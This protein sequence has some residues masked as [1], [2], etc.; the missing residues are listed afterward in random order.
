[1]TATLP[2]DALMTEQNLRIA[3]TLA[4]ER[5]R[6]ANF[7]RQRVQ[8]PAEAEDIL[9]DVFF[10]FIEAYRLP[11]P[12][13]QAGAW[14]FRVARNRIIDRFR[15]KKELP[16]PQA[17]DGDDDERWLENA[18]PATDAGPD[19]A[20]AR[21]ILL[22]EIH[23]AL[24]ELPD[25]QREAFVGHE[26]EGRSFKEL[27]AQSGVNINTLLARKRYAVLHLRARLQTI[28]DEFNR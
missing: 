14:L 20:Y 21:S 10:Q 27:A 9:Q 2:M 23:A 24:D 28:Y 7:I 13:E 12:I 16:L 4:R 17:P 8:D 19:A 11:E 25:E 15:K 18:L 5:G 26:L 22:D 3:E 6:L 1:M